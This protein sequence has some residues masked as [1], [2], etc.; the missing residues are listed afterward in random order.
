MIELYCK[1]SIGYNPTCERPQRGSFT[2][3]RQGK[4]VS[5]AGQNDGEDGEYVMMVIM[6]IHVLVTTIITMMMTC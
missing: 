5:Q 6:A 3:G 1:V 4:G 2:W